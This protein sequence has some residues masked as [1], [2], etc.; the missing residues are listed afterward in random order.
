MNTIMP[1]TP[2][3]DSMES[4]S[5][6]DAKTLFVTHMNNGNIQDISEMV[7]GAI[8]HDRL[9]LTKWMC[10][11]NWPDKIWS[12]DFYNALVQ[13]CLQV[14]ETDTAQFAWTKLELESWN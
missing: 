8:Y 14:E 7:I 11:L 13:S 4:L 2:L 10:D 5:L 1:F 9:E 6:P 12:P 3:F